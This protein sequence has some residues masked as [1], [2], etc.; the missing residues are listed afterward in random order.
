MPSCRGTS[1][2]D[3]L[4]KWPFMIP[5]GR[6]WRRE[7]LVLMGVSA[8]AGFVDARRAEKPRQGRNLTAGGVNP[9]SRRRQQKPDK[10]I[11][12]DPAPRAAGAGQIYNA[13]GVVANISGGL[14][15]R[16]E[17]V[18]ALRLLLTSSRVVLGRRSDC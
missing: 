4:P 18:A 1:N 8:D 16:L 2:A 3:Q 15:P 17:D 11:C 5:G 9:R 6:G 7:K 13:L 12:P 14:H 10:I